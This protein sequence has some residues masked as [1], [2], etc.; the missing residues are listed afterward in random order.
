MKLVPFDELTL[1]QRLEARRR[2][3]HPYFF[4]VEVHSFWVTKKG[5][6]AKRRRPIDRAVYRW[7]RQMYNHFINYSGD[8]WKK[9]GDTIKYG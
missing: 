6:F 5:Q 3:E 2:W 7:S 1:D 9:P 8:I 4:N